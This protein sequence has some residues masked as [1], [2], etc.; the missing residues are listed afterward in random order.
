MAKVKGKIAIC[1]VSSGLKLTVKESFTDENTARKAY[2]E[3]SG[4][5]SPEERRKLLLL[6]LDPS[7][8]PLLPPGELKSLIA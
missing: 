6:P 1:E 8:N 3:R 5:V 2:T 4:L 7:A